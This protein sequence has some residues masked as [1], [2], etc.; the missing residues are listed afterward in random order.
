MRRRGDKIVLSASDLMRF[1]GCEHATALDLRLLKGEALVPAA[2]TAA[3]QLIQAKG[4]AHEQSFLDTLK[5]SS[6]SVNTIDKDMLDFE[7]AVAATQA[8]LRKGPEW[9]YQAAFAGGSWGGY[10]DF[11]QRVPR[12]SKLGDFSYEV[13]DTKLKRSPDPKHVLQ[14]ALYSDLLAEV[15]GHEPVHIHVVLGDQRRVTLRLA[16][17][18]AYARH[19]RQRLED[20][21]AQPQPT[22]PEPVAA[23]D[24]CRWRE[25]CTNGWDATD[26]LCLVAGIRTNQRLKVEA[27]GVTTIA[28]LAGH[29]GKIANLAADTLDK[30]RLQARLQHARRA[31]GPPQFEARPIERGKGLMRL[32]KPADG[33]LFFDMEGDPLIEDGLEYLFGVYWEAKGV[34]IFKPFWAHDRAQER[35]ATSEVLAFFAEHLRA[36]PEA[37]IYHY[38]HYEVTALK[39]L[40]SAHGI[41]EAVLDQLLREKRFV[42]LYRI[43]QQGLVASE[44][45]YSIKNLE[46]FYA[47]KRTEEVATAGDS[48]VVYEQWRETQEPALLESIRAYN[49]TDCRS[50]K[51]LRDWLIKAVRPKGLAWPQVTDLAANSEPPDARAQREEA[52]R[53][54]LRQRFAALTGPLA[55]TP[56][57]LL[58]ELMWFHQREDKPQWWAVFDR[59]ARE[60]D[61]LIDD[62]D[63]LGGLVAHG[64]ARPEKRSQVRTYRYPEQETKLRDGVEIKVRDGRSEGALP[65]VSITRLDPEA[66]EVEVKF[67]PKAGAPPERLD[68]IPAGPLKNEVLRDAVRRV[69]QSVLAGGGRYLAIEVLLA[70]DY[71]R[72]SGLRGGTPLMAE[73]ADVVAA[74]VDIVGRLDHGTLPIQGPPG[75][76]KTYVS[77]QA[78]LA[79]IRAGKRVAVTSNS[80]KAIDNLLLAVAKRAREAKFRLK[81]IKKFSN[82]DAPDDPAIES[83]TANDDPRLASYPLVGG[84]AWLFAR[85]EQD[86]QFDYLFVDEAGQVALANIVAT[87]TA[88]RSIV[89]VGDPMQLAQPIQGTHPGQSES[90]RWLICSVTPRQCRRSAASFYP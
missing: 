59:A 60:T 87:G 89:L 74:T 20:I 38:N 69:A 52:E 70:R 72:V 27:A 66:L 49:E 86:Q 23:C 14:L 82:G 13:I 21:I 29:T 36:H 41:G 56:A 35:K 2:D 39:R 24:L 5:A 73:G 61:E 32:P 3:A 26:N 9:I 47:H 54:E 31:G 30:L 85:V 79:L 43:V 57:E 48:I 77:S 18:A 75:T 34:G 37:H 45:G 71:P 84:T 40:G 67:G 11:L 17:Y 80:H 53:G 42:D 16:D 83:T 7:E 63:S 46:V 90:R 15:Q 33:D 81:A 55:G 19:L 12:A 4:D 65:T 78:I 62:L 28:G 64:P 25:H 88:A 50:T 76:G 22:R 6:T 68:L 10:A 58:L 1:Q 51:G 8:A 44:P